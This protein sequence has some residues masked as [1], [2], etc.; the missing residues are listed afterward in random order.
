MMQQDRRV[1]TLM[2]APGQRRLTVAQVAARRSATLCGQTGSKEQSRAGQ[3]RARGHSPSWAAAW[4]ECVWMFGMKVLKYILGKTKGGKDSG[5][6]SG[7]EPR[8][9]NLE[10]QHASVRKHLQTVCSYSFFIR[11]QKKK[12]D[13]RKFSQNHGNFLIGAQ[14]LKAIYWLYYTFV[15]PWK[16][17]R[18]HFPEGKGSN[19][20]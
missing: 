8:R 12:P 15:T 3:R 4:S 1:G 9:A 14:R 7:W 16:V 5:R 2:Q 11:L 17:Q 10:I 18:F 19:T 6:W 13:T 20:L